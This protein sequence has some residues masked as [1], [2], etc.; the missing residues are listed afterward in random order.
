M[1]TKFKRFAA[2]S[3]AAMS[4][5][6]GT[7]LFAACDLGG[8]TE[9]EPT[10]Q[11][12]A[13]ST[14]V[15]GFDVSC[16]LSGWG[17]TGE[18]VETEM[19]TYWAID[20]VIYNT[21]SGSHTINGIPISSFNIDGKTPARWMVTDMGLCVEPT[22]SYNFFDQQSTVINPALSVSHRENPDG[23]GYV[24][25]V[26]TREQ[27]TSSAEE[28]TEFKTNM[29]GNY[30]TRLTL[31]FDEE[32]L[33]T[34]LYYNR[35]LIGANDGE[36][37]VQ[38]LAGYGYR[39]FSG[40]D[41]RLCVFTNYSPEATETQLAYE[42]QLGTTTYTYST[43]I[44]ESSPETLYCIEFTD[45]DCSMFGTPLVLTA[46]D[47]TIVVDGKTYT[48]KGIVN[49]TEPTVE[50]SYSLSDG[51]YHDML[52]LLT[53]EY[54]SRSVE[55]SGDEIKYA[56]GKVYNGAETLCIDFGLTSEP[57]SYTISYKGAEMII[58]GAE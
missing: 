31:F 38:N 40:A 48:G 23:D 3:V 14:K 28:E 50:K 2:L 1:K 53:G 19:H 36:T 8:S 55:V 25:V 17:L 47:F 34:E 35:Y 26:G 52:E 37:A 45:L 32:P 16:T 6:M 11:A 51:R 57:T 43:P 49:L 33:D 56:F 39:P 58:G 10:P 42:T 18:P 5:V 46:K 12:T 4:L 30:M 21:A 54:D 24:L 13:A 27:R 22:L 15:S 20:L 44:S 9:E 7:A 29:S 41:E